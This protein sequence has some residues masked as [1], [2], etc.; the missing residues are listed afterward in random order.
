MQQHVLPPV[1]NG[2]EVL[3]KEIAVRRRRVDLAQV[4]P[5]SQKVADEIFKARRG[6]QSSDFVSQH[7]GLCEFARVSF[8]AE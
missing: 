1:M 6:N 7:V 2:F 8:R 4:E 5:L 3:G